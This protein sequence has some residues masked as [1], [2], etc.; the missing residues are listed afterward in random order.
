MNRGV[1]PGSTEGAMEP[2]DYDRSVIPYLIQ[3]GQIMP[4]T[5][6]LAPPD[7]HRYFYGPDT[8]PFYATLQFYVHK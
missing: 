2:Q 3:E 6:I 1:V 8:N 7:F 5:F 4:T